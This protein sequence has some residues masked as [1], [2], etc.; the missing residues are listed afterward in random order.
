MRRFYEYD[1]QLL[2]ITEKN[3]TIKY[4]ENGKLKNK[5]FKTYF[6]NHGPIMAKEGKWISL[7]SYNRS[8]LE[9]SWLRTSLKISRIIKRPW[10]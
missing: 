2:P 6:T 9:Q 10:I 4:L 1:G 8:S 3:I 7:K 5:E